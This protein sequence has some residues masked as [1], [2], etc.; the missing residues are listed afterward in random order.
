LRVDAILMKH[1]DTSALLQA[2]V[3][4]GKPQDTRTNNLFATQ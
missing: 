4:L 3:D 2:V 1:A